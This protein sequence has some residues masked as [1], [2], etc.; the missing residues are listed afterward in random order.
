MTF[1]QGNIQRRCNAI[2]LSMT[3]RS[4]MAVTVSMPER[5]DRQLGEHLFR[6]SLYQLDSGMRHRVPRCNLFV[7]VVSLSL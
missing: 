3:Y 6:V 1:L 7:R 2:V 5:P 4:L